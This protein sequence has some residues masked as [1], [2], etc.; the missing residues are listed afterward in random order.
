MAQYLTLPNGSQFEIRQGETRA[1]ALAKALQQYPEAFGFGQAAAAAQQPESGFV[2]ALKSGVSSLKSDVAAL[3]GRTGIMDQAAAE[4]YIKEQAEYQKRTFKPTETFGE[5]PVTKT[6]ELLGGSVPYM[7]API[8][9]GALAPAGALAFGAAGAA[10]AAQFTGSNL[11]RQMQEGKAL[12]ETD[13]A[14]AALA[15]VPQAALDALSLKMLP[16]IRRIF[17]QAGK[18]ISN[19]TA[20]AIAQQSVRDVAADYAVATGKAMGTSGLTEV[21]QQALERMQAGLALTDEKARDEYFESLVGG[22]VLGGVLS[23]AGRYVERRGQAKKNS[24]ALGSPVQMPP[25]CSRPSTTR[26]RKKRMSLGAAC[27]KTVQSTRR[28]CP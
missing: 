21:G 1:Q 24:K 2:P 11:S 16:G 19:D 5:A 9:A 20:K 10:S 28:R 3:A 4:K 6:L 17:G 23:P 22:V 15:S 7:A 12:G 18:E 8:A 13:V 25:R 27:T 26:S 14:S